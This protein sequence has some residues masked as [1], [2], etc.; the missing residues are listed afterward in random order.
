MN[1]GQC[2]EMFL[3]LVLI[4]L[5]FQ[6]KLIDARPKCIPGIYI[7]PMFVEDSI[8][9]DFVQFR[10]YFK[11]CT[12]RL[13]KER[14]KLCIFYISDITLVFRANIAFL[15]LQQQSFKECSVWSD[16]WEHSTVDSPND[17]VLIVKAF[18]LTCY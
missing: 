12:A 5:L 10:S 3:H 14:N 2:G 8:E 11:N 9:S 18:V 6:F 4:F 16:C 13:H 15:S 1:F 17:E 7:L